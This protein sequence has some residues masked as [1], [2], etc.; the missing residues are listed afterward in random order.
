LKRKKEKID[1]VLEVKNKE[2]I[3]LKNNIEK[4]QNRI[5]KIES[6]LRELEQ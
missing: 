6:A 4:I 5:N 3:K 2:A 1:S